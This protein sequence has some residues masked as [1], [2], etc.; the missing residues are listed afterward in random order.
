MLRDHKRKASYRAMKATDR[1]VQGRRTDQSVICRDIKGVDT[2]K[3]SAEAA[4]DVSQDAAEI[5][6]GYLSGSE[7]RQ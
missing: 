7:A 1:T 6:E 4:T 3:C 5:L 2:E